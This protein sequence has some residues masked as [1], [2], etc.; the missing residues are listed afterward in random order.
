MKEG[1]EQRRIEDWWRIRE[2][3]TEGLGSGQDGR[4]LIRELAL[5]HKKIG[6]SRRLY[7]KG[8]GMGKWRSGMEWLGRGRVVGRGGRGRG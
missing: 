4:I 8:W 6:R 3:G 7:G 1:T 5:K 2:L